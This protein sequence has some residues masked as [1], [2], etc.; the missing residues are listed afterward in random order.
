MSHS[1]TCSLNVMVFQIVG[2]QRARIGS[3]DLLQASYISSRPET[4]ASNSSGCA[5]AEAKQ[6]A[7][8]RAREPDQPNIRAGSIG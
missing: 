2:L 5:H 6:A 7:P 8:A 1:H 4:R 3:N